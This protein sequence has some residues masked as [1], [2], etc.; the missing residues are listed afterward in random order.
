MYE[1]LDRRYAL[2]LY[3]A[4]IEAENVELVLQQLKE[5][6]NEMDSNK[7]FL[8]VI[9]NPQISKMNKK[10]IFRELFETS[11]EHELMN[12]LL[13]TIDK[14]RILYL[15]EKYEQ[16]RQIY[17]AANNIITAEVKSA[18]PLSNIERENLKIILEKKYNKIVMIKQ[19][20]D[21]SLIGG[22][23]IRIGDEIID[24]SIKN[25]LDEI[26]D[27]SNEVKDGNGNSI[28]N[29]IERRKQQRSS[30]EDVLHA[31]VTTVVPLT[32]QERTRLIESLENFYEK[33]IE[34]TED[35]DKTL[36]GGIV[37]KIGDDVTNYTVR[38]KL[39]HIQ[40]S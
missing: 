18:I 7:D 17:L 6:V 9:K 29:V 21:E 3:E 19:K 38:E 12:F 2:A 8:K 1:F 26:R 34:I 31:N 4:C 15:K 37:V 28:N 10:R 30:K 13:L 14:E 5:I 23:I 35:I 16:F 36:L 32:T 20:I 24:G 22:V 11:I 27:I 33:K 25:K 40:R 39:K